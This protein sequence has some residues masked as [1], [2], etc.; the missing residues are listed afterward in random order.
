MRKKRHPLSISQVSL[1][2]Q[3][4]ASVYPP[5]SEADSFY[6]D[7]AIL[8]NLSLSSSK[9]EMMLKNNSNGLYYEELEKI[10]RF[11]GLNTDYFENV[12]LN[13]I[14]Q[15]KNVPEGNKD[16][17]TNFYYSLCVFS[18]RNVL[19]YKRLFKHEQQFGLE[20]GDPN[21]NVYNDPDEH[22]PRLKELLE[23]HLKVGPG[24]QN[25]RSFY[26]NKEII[27]DQYSTLLHSILRVIFSKVRDYII[28]RYPNLSWL[29]G[30]IKPGT[31]RFNYS[32]AVSLA[33]LHAD[34]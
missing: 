4:S 13:D 8:D 27:K 24:I 28:E 21:K 14:K 18:A 20:H 31:A 2:S 10:R 15:T 12:I 23:G 33:L 9:R 22:L 7:Q 5:Q 34:K 25:I 30:T 1:T 6:F 11:K 32:N 19:F 26:N 3:T 16:T 17:V 29:M